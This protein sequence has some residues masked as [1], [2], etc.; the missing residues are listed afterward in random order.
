MKKKRRPRV[1]PRNPASKPHGFPVGRC[2]ANV[3]KGGVSGSKGRS[4]N[5]RC[6]SLRV[7]RSSKPKSLCSTT[8]NA[9]GVARS[10]KIQRQGIYPADHPL[11][12]KANKLSEQGYSNGI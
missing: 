11:M 4:S 5:K 6:S 1:G 8:I 12:V 7:V 3:S 10:S 9:V 2:T